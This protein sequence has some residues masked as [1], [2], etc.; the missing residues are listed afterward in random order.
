MLRQPLTRA[1]YHSTG[2]SANKRQSRGSVMLGAKTRIIQVGLQKY[3][4]CVREGPYDGFYKE[5]ARQLGEVYEVS[6]SARKAK[7][8]TNDH[9]PK[10]LSTGASE[11]SFLRVSFSLSGRE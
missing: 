2:Q 3:T 6:T 7:V 8:P 10:P 9:A 4:I 11:T 5:R 1:V